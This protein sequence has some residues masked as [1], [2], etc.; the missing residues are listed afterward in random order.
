MFELRF[1]SMFDQNR[2]FGEKKERLRHVSRDSGGTARLK[3]VFW[4]KRERL[5]HVSRDNGGTAR[6]KS[7]FF[8]EKKREPAARFP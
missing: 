1:S 7:V 5:R 2:V 3:S 4:G 8:G 6:L